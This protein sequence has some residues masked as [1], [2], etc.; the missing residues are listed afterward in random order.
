MPS[1]LGRFL[2]AFDGTWLH[3][4]KRTLADASV[5]DGRGNYDIAFFPSVKFVS[6]V[7]WSSDGLS[8]GATTRFASSFTECGSPTGIFSGN[9]LCSVNRNYSRRI[10]SYNAWDLFASYTLPTSAGRT[11]LAA[12]VNNLFDRQPSTIYNGFTA[13]SDPTAYDFLGRFVYARASHTF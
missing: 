9:G 3:S 6:G 8:A 13:A 12:G 2:L 4:Y 11:T 1:D 5:L 7:T 10:R